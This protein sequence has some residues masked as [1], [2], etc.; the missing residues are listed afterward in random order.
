M[1]VFAEFS[2]PK[3][4]YP[5]GA[6]LAAHP[7][8]S[9]EVERTVPLGG[10]VH[11]V[12][13]SGEDRWAFVDDLRADESVDEL[14]VVDELPDRTLVRFEWESGES[15]V[16][17]LAE[18]VGATP[19]SVEGARD[20]WTFRLR[21]LEPAALADFY[22]LSQRRGIPLELQATYESDGAPADADT[23]LTVTQAETLVT[24]FE[25][26]YFDVPRRVTLAELAEELD[27]SEQAVSERLRRGLFA[28]LTSVGFGESDDG[29]N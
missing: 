3:T 19:V 4:A 18:T 16:F 10:S 14:T 28:L 13:V 11:Y 22:D 7:D 1:S 21:F 6:T 20:G 26:G 9:V 25:S 8:V 2:A 17:R 29:A 5:L 23:D 27:V 12:W 24:A 15:P